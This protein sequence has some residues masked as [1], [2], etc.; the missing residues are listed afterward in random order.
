MEILLER[1]CVKKPRW[2]REEDEVL[3]DHVK[4]NGARNWS[5]VSKRLCQR[6]G[7]SCRHRWFN[8]LKPN[9]KTGKFS[10]E[11]EKSVIEKQK[12]FGNKWATIAKDLPGRTD[13]DVKNFWSSRRKR[14]ERML[15]KS[16]GKTPLTQVLA[17]K[18]P[19]C[20]SNSQQMENDFMNAVEVEATRLHTIPSFESS[21]G[22]NFPLLPEPLIDFPVFPEYRDLVLETFDLNFIDGFV[23]NICQYFE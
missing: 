7:K 13:N 5:I 12:Q 4:E 11:E 22:Y 8:K 23:E 10:A 2:S 1:G 6:T 20:S 16:K 9:L 3:R 18:A 19:P 17:E 15:Q 14:L 21:L